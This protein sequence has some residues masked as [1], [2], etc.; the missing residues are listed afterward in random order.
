MFLGRNPGRDEDAQDRPFVGRAGQLLRNAVHTAGLTD[1]DIIYTNIV[2]C[3]TPEN[4]PPTTEEQLACRPYLEEELAT[5]S[6]RFVFA[7]GA[8]AIAFWAGKIPKSVLALQGE[9]WEIDGRYVFPM[10]HPSWVLRQG[11][12]PDSP[13]AAEREF[14]GQ[15]QAHLAFI[16]NVQ[17][18]DG[19][20][21]PGG[22]PRVVLCR[23]MAD[24]TAALDDL[25]RCERV[26]VDTE[27]QGLWWAPDRCTD[28]TCRCQ[29]HHCNEEAHVSLH[30]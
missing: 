24:V 21:T 18:G 7:F 6:P 11:G 25:E 8:E 12:P 14:Q 26:A 2:R 4:R 29:V 19:G 30:M 17:N 13:S 5:S 3:L 20:A 1:E 15:I 28:P 23:T 16:R 22:R 10:P 27:T 9:R